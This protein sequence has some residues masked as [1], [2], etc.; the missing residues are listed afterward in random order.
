MKN[1][2]NWINKNSKSLKNKNV[3]VLGATGSIGIETCKYLSYLNANIYIAIRNKD[4]GN[5]LINELKIEY[6][7]NNYYLLI[8]DLSSSNSV[9]DFINVIKSINIDYFISCA[10]IYHLN[11]K[12]LDDNLEIHFAT[13]YFNQIRIV[14]SISDL[15]LK[16]NGKII[17]LGS[18]SYRFNNIDLSDIMSLNTSNKTKVYARSKRLLIIH[19]LKLIKD[20]AP[21]I[22]AHPGVCPTTLF[23]SEKG[24]FS[25][26][27]NKTIFPIMKL[28]FISPKKAALNVIYAVFNDIDYGYQIG[29]RGLF[30][31]WGYPKKHRFN[32]KVLD[33]E[34]Q[35]KIIT[36][37]DNILKLGG[38]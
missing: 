34:L 1:Y 29:P 12:I 14:E 28:I 22:I 18:I 2:Y 35:T 16:R 6:P 33:D 13:N 37:Y 38:M 26:L 7:D 24:G 32:K 25:K 15:V 17:V 5:K 30:H 27:F 4:K 3:I 11:K 31:V 20:G 36:E 19:L 23:A 21:I 10:G 9:N 8:V